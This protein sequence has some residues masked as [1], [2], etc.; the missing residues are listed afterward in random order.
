MSS[1]TPSETETLLPST[2]DGKPALKSDGG[3]DVPVFIDSFKRNVTIC[4]SLLGLGLAGSLGLEIWCM[5]QTFVKHYPHH[6]GRDLDNF[7][8]WEKVTNVA[9]VAMIVR[10]L[11]F[12]HRTRLIESLLLS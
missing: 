7:L 10:P 6:A 8:L 5:T 11:P 9:C 12:G 2:P 3:R 4:K 1:G